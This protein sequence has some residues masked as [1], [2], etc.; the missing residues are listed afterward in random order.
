ML[1]AALLG[2]IILQGPATPAK[3]GVPPPAPGQQ[4]SKAEAQHQ[5]DIDGDIAAGKRF[6]QEVEK[7]EK[8]TENKEFQARV[9]RIGQEIAAIAQT[10]K[11]DV[12]WGDKRLNKFNY[13]FKVIK[14]EDVNAFSLPGG[15]IY[16]YEGLIKYAESD[17]E[18]AAVLA[19]EITH[20]E[21]RHI[22]T[23]TREQQKVTTPGLL[24]TLIAIFTKNPELI[25]ATLMTSQLT[26]ASFTSTW[27]VKAEQAADHGGI[28]YLIHSKY[29]PTAML[30][31]MERLAQD[32]HNTPAMKIDW[33]IYRNHPPGSERAE[34]M[35]ADMKKYGV[36][37][38]RSIVTTRY[39]AEVKPGK[40]GVEIW[41][42]KRKLYTC[43]G[44]D[45]LQRADE[46]A[47]RLNKFFDA[48]PS[49]ID[50]DFDGKE[51][52]GRRSPLIDVM[53]EDAA[54]V[55]LSTEDLGRRAVTAIKG[56]LFNYAFNIWGTK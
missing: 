16:V 2:A 9:D 10:T 1:T 3:G 39:R 22:A 54:V 20:S 52:L 38:Q 26:A 24:A 51:I 13:T 34:A 48:E 18:L 35:L 12:S 45:A 21:A 56:S 53:P 41:F 11:I 36:P 55:K 6:V 49:L 46:A 4:V 27:S 44:S 5:K 42:N 50:V 8:L 32:E 28:Q 23:L 29:N 43:A 19:H 7:T 15:F 30:T 31:F 40:D 17:D 37:V 47:A 25:E 14:G 33:G